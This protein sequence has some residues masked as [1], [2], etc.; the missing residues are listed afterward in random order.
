M[1]KLKFD[2]LINNYEKYNHSYLAVDE[3][4]LIAIKFKNDFHEL[5]ISKTEQ[6]I[7]FK[8]YHRK[9]DLY[10]DLLEFFGLDSDKEYVK[11]IILKAI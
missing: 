1:A 9:L 5:T 2:M 4:V 3:N 6:H 8:K 11:T 10:L 7:W